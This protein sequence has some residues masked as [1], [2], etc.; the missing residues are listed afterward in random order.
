METKDIDNIIEEKQQPVPR[1]RG[2]SDSN[3]TY[4]L[5]LP[6]NGYNKT[7]KNFNRINKHS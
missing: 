3:K 5:E 1:K 7:V 6:K 2:T 4:K